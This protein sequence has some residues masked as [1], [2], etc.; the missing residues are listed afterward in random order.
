MRYLLEDLDR[1]FEM[2]QYFAQYDGIEF[3][4]ISKILKSFACKLIVCYLQVKIYFRIVWPIALTIGRIEL[5]LG[6]NTDIIDDVRNI[7]SG[8]PG[9]RKS[10]KWQKMD[11]MLP[12]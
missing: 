1:V 8:Y 12:S 2:L 11:L 9:K 3:V 5:R 7:A 4:R 6:R 10:A